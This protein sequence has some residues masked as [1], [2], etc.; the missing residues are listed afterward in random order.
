MHKPQ[1][2]SKDFIQPD[3]YAGV[4]EWFTTLFGLFHD[5]SDPI[6][7]LTGSIKPQQLALSA[8][9]VSFIDKSL[10]ETRLLECRR[11]LSSSSP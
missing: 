1:R 10:V 7:I 8:T 4:I 3:D 11:K 9:A 5:V 2:I 6:L